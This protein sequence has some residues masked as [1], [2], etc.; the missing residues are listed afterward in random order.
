M[1]ITKMDATILVVYAVF[2]VVGG[3]LFPAMGMG[4]TEQTASDVPEF[5]VSTSRF[6]FVDDLPQYPSEPSSGVL[7]ATSDKFDDVR[8]T[9]QVELGPG[10]DGNRTFIVS[11][12]SGGVWITDVEEGTID[13]EHVFTADGEI[14][15]LEGQGYEID[16]HA[17]DLSGDEFEFIVTESPNDSDIPLIGGVLDTADAVANGVFW[18]GSTIVVLVLMAVEGAAN[19]GGLMFDVATY[20]VDL[21]GWAVGFATGFVSGAPGYAQVVLTT[22]LTPLFYVFAKSGIILINMVN[23]FG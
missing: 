11:N 17:S 2:A 16:V 1:N 14:H 20:F 10:S 8:G 4:G 19:T 13:D 3:F 12:T 21:G 9:I 18:I 15:T 5:N 7:N 6:D 22:S 23:P